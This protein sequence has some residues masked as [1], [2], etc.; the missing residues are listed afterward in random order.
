MINEVLF[1]FS[2]YGFGVFFGLLFKRQLP[3]ALIGATGFLWGTLFWVLGGIVL[4]TT[5]IP[6]TPISIL[7][8]FIILGL[9]I[10]I[11][12]ARNKTWQLSRNELAYLLPIGF[13]FLLALLLASKF[14]FSYVSSDSMKQLITGRRIAYEGLSSGVIEELSL[15]GIFLSQLQ[16]AGVF[17][18]VDYLVAAQPAFAYTFILTFFFLSRQVIGHLFSDHKR[19]FV[20]S[21]LTTL[22]LCSTYFIVFQFFYIHNSLISAVYLLT[23]VISIWLAFREDNHSW[24]ILGI[25]A[26]LGFSLARTESPLFALIFFLLVISADHIPFQIRWRTILPPLFLLI[27]WYSYLFARMGEGTKILDPEKTLVIIVAL[28]ACSI[29]VL[30]SEL[31]WIKRY[32]LPYLPKIMLGALVLILLLMVVQKPQHMRTSLNIIF[33]N[34]GVYGRWGITWLVFSLLFLVSLL[35]PRFPEEQFFFVGISSYFSLLMAIVYFRNP[36]RI[37]WYDSA[38]RLLTH[39]LPIVI[40]YVLMKAAHGFSGNAIQ[41]RDA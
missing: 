1:L 19:A 6:Y 28:I 33:L 21:L 14:N 23:A 37:G 27:V 8:V 39:I 20:L 16:S 26:L 13:G 29:L 9:G 36:W 24:V 7:T 22:A 25:L 12:H 30:L 18:K 2:L 41:Y 11:L 3:P 4:L 32:L 34:T 35:G 15:R 10:G 5:S 17:L 40:L 38:N 31:R